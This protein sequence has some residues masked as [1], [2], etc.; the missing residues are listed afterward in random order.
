MTITPIMSEPESE[1][2]ASDINQMQK[3][4]IYKT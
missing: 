4:T 1:T 3:F 2:Q